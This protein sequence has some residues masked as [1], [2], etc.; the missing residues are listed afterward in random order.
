[1]GLWGAICFNLFFNVIKIL[2]KKINVSDK[3]ISVS[4]FSTNHFLSKIKFIYS[5]R[6]NIL[7]QVNNYRLQGIINKR[8]FYRF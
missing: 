7:I 6:H 4:L 8:K 2:C 3:N 1:M 5:N